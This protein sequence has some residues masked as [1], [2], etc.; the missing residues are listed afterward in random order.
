MCCLEM[1]QE[2]NETSG[3]WDEE[4]HGQKKQEIVWT[5]GFQDLIERQETTWTKVM[6]DLI[7]SLRS[8]ESGSKEIHTGT[9]SLFTLTT[10]YSQTFNGR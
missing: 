3:C 2:Q 6:Q 5:K 7:E 4:N 8:K 10:S 9:I 1:I